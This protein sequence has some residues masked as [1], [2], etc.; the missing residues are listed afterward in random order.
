MRKNA[1]KIV[2]LLTV[3]TL[4]LGCSTM[5]EAATSSVKVIARVTD[6]TTGKQ[7]S[8]IPVISGHQ[9]RLKNIH[10][11]DQASR[12]T[13]KSTR[14]YFEGIKPKLKPDHQGKRAPCTICA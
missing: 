6:L 7:Y 8:N 2:T 13:A 1:K 14:I 5:A 4:V 3:L 10:K 12:H 9:L 11:D